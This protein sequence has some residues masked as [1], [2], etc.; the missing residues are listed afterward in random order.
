MSPSPST[1]KLRSRPASQLRVFCVLAFLAV[2]SWCAGDVAA[3]TVIP[4]AQP[5]AAAQ[6]ALAL[7][8]SLTSMN[9]RYRIARQSERSA[10]ADGMLAAASKR[11]ELLLALMN[12]DPAAVLAATLPLA[13]RASLP[14]SIAA[15]VEQDAVVEGTLEILHEDWDDGGRYHYYLHSAAGRQSLHFARS[16]PDQLLTGARVRVKGVQLNDKLALGDTTTGV[17]QLAPAPPPIA[18]GEQRTVVILV[19]FVDAPTQPYTIESARSAI[20]DATSAFFQENS[21]QQTWLAGDVVGWFTIPVSS[22]SCD[23]ASI[24]SYAQ[25]A[26]TAAGVN[27]ASYAHQVYAFPQNACGWW[28]LSSVG[29]SPSQSW[30]NGSFELAVLAHELGHGHGLWHSHSLDCGTTSVVGANCT[31]NEYGDIIDMMGASHWAHYN[32][33]QKERLGWLNYGVSPPITTVVADG[34]YTIEPYEASGHGPK[35]LKILKSTDAIT[36][37]KTWYYVEYRQ[38]LGFDAALTDFSVGSEN[39]TTGVLV[40]TGSESGGDTAFLIDMTPA[41]P[42]YYWWYDPALAVGQT[43]TDPDSGLTITTAWVGPTG[44]GATIHVGKTSPASTPAVSVAT[45]QASY[46]RGQTASVSAKVTANGLPLAKASVSFTIVKPNGAKLVANGTTSSSGIAVYKLRLA[47]QDPIGLWRADA[48]A[49][50][51][52]V[53]SQSSATFNVQ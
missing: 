16:A 49:S 22:A 26:A 2:F 12:D 17:Q 50:S 29:G 42:V 11:F 43:F 23:Y 18:I 10:L 39:V 8:K 45:N 14:S 41:T 44:A 32:A 13:V 27:L 47:K 15:Y 1:S 48:K 37:Q 36:G 28:G 51:N 40:H 9:A 6:D 19:N 46:V 4:P 3:H 35:A 52:G 30:I 34:T 24:A 25:S 53:S 5:S 21:Y 33:F 31:T 20:F 7:S 38:P